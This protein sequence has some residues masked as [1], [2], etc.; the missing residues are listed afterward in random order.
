MTPIRLG[1]VS[2]LN[3]RPLVSGL[4]RQPNRFSVRF[5]LP[6]RC[7]ALLHEGAV[8]LGLIPS[9]EYLARPNYRIVP[10]LSI[11]SKGPVASVALFASRPVAALRSIAVDNSSRTSIAL[12]RLLCAQWFEIEPK[13]VTVPP[14]LPSMLKRCDAAMLIGDL[15]LW[16]DP[17][18]AGLDKVDLGEE[19]TAMTGKPFVWAF[20]AGRPDVASPEAVTALQLARDTGTAS[21]DEIAREYGGDDEDKVEIGQAY[22]RDNIEYGLGE[23]QLAGLRKF[24]DLASDRR[25]IQTGG[26]LRFY[27]G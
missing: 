27:E 3:A 16:T 23:E 8:D 19:W 6:S 25:I 7:A 12:L 22:L 15:A 4:D 21:L 11:C 17:D 14:D 10:G 26:S 2:Y 9:I 18:V 1:A 24:F 13:F 5:D 20:W